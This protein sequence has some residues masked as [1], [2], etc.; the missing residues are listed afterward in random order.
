MESKIGMQIFSV[1]L[2]LLLVSL[3]AVPAVSAEKTSPRMVDEWEKEHTIP[4]EHTTEYYFEKG[5]LRVRDIYSGPDL[6]ARFNKDQLEK[7]CSYQM[8]AETAEKMGYAEGQRYTITENTS[9]VF[10]SENDPPVTLRT[11][12]YPQWIYE[13]IEDTYHQLDE[14]VNIAWENNNLNTVKSEMLD[15]GWWDVIAEDVYYIYD[16]EWKA[17]DGVANDPVRLFGGWHIRLW[18]MAD[19]DVVGAAHHDSAVPHHADGFENA[20]EYIAAFYDQ[21][22]DDMWHVFEDYYALNNYVAD[23]YNNGMCTSIYYW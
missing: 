3:I 10:T 1:L 9:E 20:E 4:V 22:D 11:Y 7:T 21:P 19:G 15:E 2:A 5:Q 8:E 13:K 23:P 17:D 6:T 18:Q 16:N 12:D 14:P